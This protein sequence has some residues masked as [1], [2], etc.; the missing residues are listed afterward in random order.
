MADVT[1]KANENGPFLVTGPATVTDHQGNV[2]EIGKE[3][4]ALC[5][6][7]ASKNR[8]FCDGSH[9]ASGFTSAELAKPAG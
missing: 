3:V 6:C 5:R 2:F 1:I 7:A 4:F 9:K 8:P